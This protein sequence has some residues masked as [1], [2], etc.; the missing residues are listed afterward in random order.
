[1]RAHACVHVLLATSLVVLPGCGGAPAPAATVSPASAPAPT[2]EYDPSRA[3][4]A[5][6]GDVQMAGI[7]PD[8][9]TFADARALRAP[10]D[11]LA[12]YVAAK[13]SP[14]FDLRAFVAQNFAAPPDAGA[15][16]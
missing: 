6:F 2:A 5:L 1:M 3:L 9:K 11:I 15:G 10:A 13:S 16:V 8:S 7:F 12:S 14:G 4:G